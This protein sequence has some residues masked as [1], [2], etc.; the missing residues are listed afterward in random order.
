M[1]VTTIDAEAMKIKELVFAL[2]EQRY[3]QGGRQLCRNIKVMFDI[4]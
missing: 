3:P 4:C 2:K 1:V